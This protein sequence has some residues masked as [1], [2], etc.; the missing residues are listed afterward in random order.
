VILFPGWRRPWWVAGS[1]PLRKTTVALREMT[2][3][4]RVLAALP[5]ATRDEVGDLV[6][7]FN[8]LVRDIDDREQMRPLRLKQSE[9]RYRVLLDLSPD[10]IFVH[11]DGVMAMANRSALR[12]F[13]AEQE[14]QL[15][16]QPWTARS[17]PG[18]SRDRERNGCQR[19]RDAD[20]SI[21]LPPDRA[22]LSA[23]GRF[24][25]RG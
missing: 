10:A 16:G 1:E 3:G 6:A 7:S 8:E 22:T 12:L 11:R 5:V 17:S 9:A 21:A 24:C 25:R 14:E 13:G 2:A 20:G 4:R 23:S 19:V 15:L 18:F